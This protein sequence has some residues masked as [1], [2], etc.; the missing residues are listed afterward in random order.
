MEMEMCK[1]KYFVIG[2]V[3][4]F[5]Q[6]DAMRHNLQEP[7]Y[8]GEKCRQIG[9]DTY[10][11]SLR[12]DIAKIQTENPG[13]EEIME[14]LRDDVE[15]TKDILSDT[16]SESNSSDENSEVDISDHN[17]Y[18]RH[19]LL[20]LYTVA[21]TKFDDNHVNVPADINGSLRELKI[22]E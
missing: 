4:T 12:S 15:A 11:D 14:I 9:L 22:I 2:V 10:Y 1:F 3:F 18:C 16:D 21:K 8:L 5:F 20:E 17:S 13:T 7:D 19:A 6:V